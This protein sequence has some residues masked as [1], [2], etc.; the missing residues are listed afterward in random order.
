MA[1]LLQWQPWKWNDGVHIAELR[2][3]LAELLHRKAYLFDSGRSALLAG[4]QAMDLQPDDEVI[5]QGYTC[6][7]VPNAVMAAGGTPVYADIQEKSL[8]I[9]PVSVR[10]CITPRTRAIICQH[11]FGIPADTS[12]L[13]LICNE[14]SLALIEDRAHTIPL[15]DTS[16]ARSQDGDIVILSFGR[17]KAISGVAGGAMLTQHDAIANNLDQMERNAQPLS[18]WEI[19]NLIGYPLRYQCAKWIWP[20]GL[21]KVYL[22]LLQLL[23][24]L[25][26]VLTSQ[27]KQG[28]PSQTLQ[29][30]PNACAGLVH[31]QLELLEAFSVHRQKLATL[32]TT[33]VQTNGWMTPKLMHSAK[34]P[35]K[36]ILLIPE[37]NAVRATLKRQQVYLDDGWCNA[38][39]NPLS[40]DQSAVRYTAGQCPVA[41]SVCKRVLALPTHPTMRSAQ[42]RDLVQMLCP[43]LRT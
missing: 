6:V 25:P 2:M 35:Q 1:A 29:A 34:A 41:E 14:H 13:R 39:V 21:G 23:R 3:A 32:Y 18:R 31:Q 16:E 11:T 17:D 22:R 33:A 37:A 43:L 5:I 7:A 12:A 38:V 26:P 30:M 8:N 10:S 20:T 24:L 4:L 15:P 36:Y 19:L 40:V 42:A 9:D 27:E 28:K